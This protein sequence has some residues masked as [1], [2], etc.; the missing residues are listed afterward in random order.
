M[1]T[2]ITDRKKGGRE[3]YATI[4]FNVHGKEIISSIQRSLW[5]KT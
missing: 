2:C 4:H 5:Q 1:Y 3:R